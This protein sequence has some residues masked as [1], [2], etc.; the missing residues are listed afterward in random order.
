MRSINKIIVHCSATPRNKD[1]SAEDIRDWH[2]KGNGW[3][4][5]GYHFVIRLDGSIEYG[6]M[7]DK[8]GAHAKGNNYDSIGVCYIGGM[9]K[10]MTEWE[11]TRTE[12][13]KESLLI[14]LKTFK[15]LHKNVEIYG[16][17]NFST[18]MCPSFD[19]KEEYKDIT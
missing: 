2:V 4:D 12:Q 8:Y 14:L 19:A 5:I 1:F 10:D 3:D 13:Q 11:D 9:N 16:H 7:V 15:K 17:R 18:K 6:R